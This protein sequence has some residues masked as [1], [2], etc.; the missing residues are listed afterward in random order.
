MDLADKRLVGI[1]SPLEQQLDKV[2]RRELIGMIDAQARAIVGTHVGRRVVHVDSEEK[3]PV[4]RIGSK[5]EQG[6]GEVETVV[7]DRDRRRGNTVT[8]RGFQIGAALGER[9][10]HILVTVA[11]G[12]HQC[13]KAAR[14]V[15]GVFPFGQFRNVSFDVRIRSGGEQRSDDIN[16]SLRRRISAVSFW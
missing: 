11:Y 4:V 8:V 14:R 2:E 5:V 7:D 15:I 13:G 10:H 9:P 12:E 6:L 3:R 16:M 1:G